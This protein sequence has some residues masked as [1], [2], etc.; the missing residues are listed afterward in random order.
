[1]RIV[2]H[3]VGGRGGTFSFNPPK[4]FLKSL[5]IYL[6]EADESCLERD[7]RSVGD[8]AKIIPYLL[9]GQEGGCQFHLNVSA[10]TSSIYPLNDCYSEYNRVSPEGYEYPLGVTHKS[11]KVI[12]LPSHSLNSLCNSPYPPPPP[13]Y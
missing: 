3:H 1:M 12:N 4:N 9:A 5:D 6:Y 8:G 2:Y 13:K 10:N 11:V 7:M